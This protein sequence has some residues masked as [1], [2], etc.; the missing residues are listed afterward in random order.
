MNNLITD[1][2]R[3]DVSKAESLNG[4][5]WQDMSAVEQVDFMD[6]KGAYD[7]T[8]LNRVENAVENIM[9][10]FNNLQ[11][12]LNAY[13]SSYGVAPDAFWGVPYNYPIDLSVKTNWTRL[14]LPVASA[15]SRYLNNVEVITDIFPI[16]RALPA[17]MENLTYRGANEIERALERE[18]N[19]A[20]LWEEEKK[21]HA[22]N[23]A[24]AFLYS[25]D[26]YCGGYYI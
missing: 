12:T 10:Y 7:Y 14:D 9:D 21:R 4:K 5:S 8:D 17:S 19:T 1:R 13:L 22:R 3:A 16:D 24:M 15:M 20:S 23:T 2:A 11:D 25:G 6:L 18:Y 26:T